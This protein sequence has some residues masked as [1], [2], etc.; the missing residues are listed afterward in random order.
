MTDVALSFGFRIAMSI[1]ELEL[2]IF[3]M[4]MLV[5][6]SPNKILD[7][8]LILCGKGLLILSKL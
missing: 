3:T 7:T 2:A 1:Q 4:M 5:I 6:I 8:V